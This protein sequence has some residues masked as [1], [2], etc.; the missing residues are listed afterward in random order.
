MAV[1]VVNQGKGIVG[2]FGRESKRISQGKIAG[3]EN[4]FAERSVFVVGRNDA[5]VR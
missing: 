5:V 1:V 3:R 4:H 2:V